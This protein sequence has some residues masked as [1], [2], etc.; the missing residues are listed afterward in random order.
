MP[1]DNTKKMHRQDTN[2]VVLTG[3]LTRDVDL[4]KPDDGGTA[5]A[6]MRI[7]VNGRRKVRGEWVD[8]PNYFTVVDFGVSAENHARYLKKGRLIH[9]DG[10]LD[11]D[12]Y[13]KNGE[14]R[15][16]V[17]VI[18]SNVQYLPTKASLEEARA[19]ATT[20]AQGELGAEQPTPAVAGESE[21]G[22]EPVGAAGGLGEEPEF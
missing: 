22:A 17:K 11:W 6:N 8:K 2:V 14:T 16:E 5:V 9:V 15:H 12:E 10:R 4:Y 7:A 3:N 18:A 13:E 21:Q 1:S 20:S 19:A